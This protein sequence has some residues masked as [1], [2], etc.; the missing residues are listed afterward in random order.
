[1]KIPKEVK[2]IIDKLEKEGFEA[3]VVGGC[4]RDSLRGVKPSDWDIATDAPSEK[5]VE[6]FPHN[7]EVEEFGLVTVITESKD[8][9]LKEIEIMRFRTEAGYDDHRH[10]DEVEWVGSIEED[11]ARRDFTVNALAMN[12]SGEII[13]IYEGQEDLEKKIIRA[14]G[15]PDE[16][17]EEDALRLIRAIRFASL[18]PDW[19]IEGETKAS[20]RD[21]APLLEKVSKERI[22]DEFVKIIMSP[23]ARKGV[24]LMKDTGLLPFVLPELQENVGVAQN[25]HHEFNC[26]DHAVN[27]LHYAVENDYSKYVR[28]A[29]L[30]HDI[31]KPR[32]KEGEGEEAT[33]YNHEMEGAKM[34]E[35]ILTR[36]RFPK[37]TIKRVTNLVRYHLFYYNVGEVTESSVRKLVRN[38]GRENMEDLLRVRYSDRIGSGCP[39]AVPYKLRHLQYVIEKTSKDP[40]S[41]K[42]LKVSGDDIMKKLGIG[43]GPKVGQVLDILLSEVLDDPN[44]DMKKK[45]NKRV[46]KLGSMTDKGLSDLAQEAQAS[47]KEVKMKKDRKL[48]DKYWL[49]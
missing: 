47:V 48:K 42:M 36:L 35:E 32:V 19:R 49:S 37:E 38:V 17:F 10:P 9:T 23:E 13:D 34:T 5:T 20:I 6:L 22:R 11:L 26:Y 25:K 8:E 29:T 30:L 14:V 2:K 12:S 1:M 27:S 28:L 46:E 31:A 21:K 7:F 4:V 39:K 33:F 3:Y 43:Q 41:T 15:D 24:N 18:G 45:L 44:L 40:I 16:R